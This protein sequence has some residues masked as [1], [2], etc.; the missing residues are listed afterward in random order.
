MTVQEMNLPSQGNH[1]YR[2][3]L[4]Y[5]RLEPRHREKLPHSHLALE[6][7][8]FSESCRG[9]YV[10]GET[11]YPIMPGDIFV[12]RSNEEHSI[13]HMEEGADCICTGLQ[14]SPDFIWSPGNELC[15]MKHVYSLFSGANGQFDNKLDRNCERTEKIRA[16]IADIVDEFS[17]EN[18]DYGLMVKVK[19]IS[20]LI[21]LARK[22]DHLAE[23][24]P[25]VMIKREN[26]VHIENAMSY[27]DLHLDEQLTLEQLAEV[28]NMSVSYFSLLFKTL[29]G[30]SAWEYIVGKRIELAQTLLLTSE[31]PVLNIVF[32]SGFNNT[33][34]FN[35]AF[36]RATGMSPREYRRRLVYKAG[37]ETD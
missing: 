32:K 25:A 1:K 12:L 15:D 20:L 33:T 8:V 14:F 30:F 28:A 36:K 13:V 21:L 22:Y 18:L 23:S 31:E 34:N 10:I 24:D 17:D 6:I 37:P 11:E 2:V 9:V 29:N 19:L 5:N 35:R 16:L 26:R 27:I 3:R 7:N 4:Y